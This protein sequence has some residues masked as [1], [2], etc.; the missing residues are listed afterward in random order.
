M[1]HEFVDVLPDLIQPEEYDSDP[2]GKRVRLRIR[3]R[4]DGIEILG[5]SVRPRSLESLLSQLE[6]RKVEQMLCG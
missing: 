2:E 3:V 5:D 6:V 1:E 4:D